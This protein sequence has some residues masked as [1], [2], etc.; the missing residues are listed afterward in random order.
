MMFLT[1]IARVAKRGATNDAER[2][3]AFYPGQG[4]AFLGHIRIRTPS[5]PVLFVSSGPLWLA[6]ENRSR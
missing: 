5:F 2:R 1:Q 6:H 4:E 3:V